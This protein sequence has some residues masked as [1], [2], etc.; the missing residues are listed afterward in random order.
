MPVCAD[1]AYSVV[2][3]ARSLRS[4]LLNPGLWFAAFSTHKSKTVLFTSSAWIVNRAFD[5]SA[6]RRFLRRAALFKICHQTT[7]DN[8]VIFPCHQKIQSL[9]SSH[10]LRSGSVWVITTRS[11]SRFPELQLPHRWRVQ[12]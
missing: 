10:A 2:L 12:L 5:G 8:T 4:S 7:P 9:V 11:Q 3:K 1:S 6:R